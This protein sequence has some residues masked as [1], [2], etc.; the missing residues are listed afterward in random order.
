MTT[1]TDTQPTPRTDL[2]SAEP[3]DFRAPQRVAKDQW[4]ALQVVCSRLAASLESVLTTRLRQPISATLVRVEELTV[5]EAIATLTTPCA[6]YVFDPGDGSGSTGIL[7]LGAGL[8]SYAVDRLLG[9]PGTTPDTARAMTEMEQRIVRGVVERLLAAV[10]EGFKELTRM[11]PAVASCEAS[12]ERLVEAVS[13][14]G[15]MVAAF[16]IKIDKPVGT[17]TLCLPLDALAGG[18]QE[19]RAAATRTTRT[20]TVRPDTR[21][22]LEAAVRRAHV[23]LMVQFPAITLPA[24][25][26]AMLA[27]GQTIQT[28]LPLDVAVEVRVNGRLRFLGAPGQVH[29]TVGVRIVRPVPVGASGTTAPTRA[30]IL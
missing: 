22:H 18:F 4:A 10:A 11:K 17:V 9:G 16:E 5:A 2:G 7:D 8:A 24:R 20:A 30:R 13:G 14:D 23:P 28:S 15:I 12:T 29:G 6:A 21:A 25:A 27:P 19:R 26:V 3:Y 1:T